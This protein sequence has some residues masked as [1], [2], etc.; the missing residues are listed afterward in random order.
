MN[1]LRLFGY[2]SIKNNDCCHEKGSLTRFPQRWYDDLQ[3]DAQGAKKM[4]IHD[5]VA[6]KLWESNQ[7]ELELELAR[8]RQIKGSNTKVTPLPVS[9]W[10]MLAAKAA[11]LIR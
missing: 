3:I 9:W 1:S 8:Q 7:K 4:L 5:Y 10:S 6:Y 2:V 11:G